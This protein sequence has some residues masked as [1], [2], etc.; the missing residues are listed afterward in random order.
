MEM[1][2]RILARSILQTKWAKGRIGSRK[3]VVDLPA[4]LSLLKTPF[5][6]VLMLWPN[7]RHAATT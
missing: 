1:D 2:E 4:N 7:D 5:S 6:L 3:F